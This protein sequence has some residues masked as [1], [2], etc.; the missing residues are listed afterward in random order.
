MLGLVWLLE[1]RRRTELR[2]LRPPVGR[3]GMILFAIVALSWSIS[4]AK[5]S[6]SFDAN[7]AL[8][9]PASH[10]SRVRFDPAGTASIPRPSGD[11]FLLHAN[12]ESYVLWDPGGFLDGQGEIRTLIV[13]RSAVEWIDARRRF[14]LQ[15]GDRF[16]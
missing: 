5:H 3:A 2:S 12:R 11:C 16:L 15:P 4:T 14:Q 13:P 6:G 10:L 8:R 9:D 1:P 7:L